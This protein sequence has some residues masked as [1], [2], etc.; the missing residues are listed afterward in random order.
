MQSQAIRY[1]LL[2]QDALRGM[3]RDLLVKVAREGLPGDH[4][5]FITF[6]THAPGVQLSARMKARYPDE[7]TIV[8]Q[9]QFWDLIVGDRQFEVGLSFSN[10]PE[11]L[12]V[13]FTSLSGFHDPSV[14]FMLKFEPKDAAA[15][16]E[17]STEPTPLP[18][19]VARLDTI[20]PDATKRGKRPAAERV[21]DGDVEAADNSEAAQEPAAGSDASKVVS[22]DSFRKKP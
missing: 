19:P 15:A 6:K 14:P 8:L 10:I 11:R 13:P 2:V 4:H 7:I 5:F 17:Q 12:I 3:V 16:E 20:K 9:H 22:I 21:A 18:Q 1:D